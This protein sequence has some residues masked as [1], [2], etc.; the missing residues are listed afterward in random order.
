MDKKVSYTVQ[1]ILLKRTLTLPLLLEFFLKCL[2]Y[3]AYHRK[4]GF[5]TYLLT[6]VVLLTALQQAK[7]TTAIGARSTK[8]FILSIRRDK[9]YP[10]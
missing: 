7:I 1:A 6:L 3:P 4:L 9:T 5:S 2:L 10:S 8:S